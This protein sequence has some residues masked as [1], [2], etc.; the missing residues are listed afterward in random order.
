MFTIRW[1][2]VNHHKASS[3]ANNIDEMAHSKASY[4]VKLYE[5]LQTISNFK[6]EV[7]QT[8]WLWGGGK[9]SILS[10]KLTFCILLLLNTHLSITNTLDTRTIFIWDCNFTVTREYIDCLH[11]SIEENKS[12]DIKVDTLNSVWECEIE[13]DRTRSGRVRISRTARGTRRELF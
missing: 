12:R 9:P 2:H 6:H 7:I 10:V 1:S 8:I 3:D 4:S 13:R 5:I 11:I